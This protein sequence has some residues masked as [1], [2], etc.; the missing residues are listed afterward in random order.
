MTGPAESQKAWKQPTA[1]EAGTPGR[2]TSHRHWNCWLR[3]GAC[4]TNSALGE[5]LGNWDRQG[6]VR[7]VRDCKGMLVL[8]KKYSMMRARSKSCFWGW[9][10]VDRTVQTMGQ[11]KKWGIRRNFKLGVGHTCLMSHW[12]YQGCWC[13]WWCYKYLRQGI[14]R[15]RGKIIFPGTWSCLR[16][17]LFLDHCVQSYDFGQEWG[18]QTGLQLFLLA[19]DIVIHVTYDVVLRFSYFC[20]KFNYCSGCHLF[21]TCI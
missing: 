4:T 21:L 16:N 5:G 6:K 17:V 8:I 18:H 12:D 19:L 15:V 11:E 7:F 9:C 20:S 14:R 2:N 10:E 3:H 13:S 1:N